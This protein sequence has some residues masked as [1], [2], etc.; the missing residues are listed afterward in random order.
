MSLIQG[1]RYTWD[2]NNYEDKTK[3]GLFTGEYDKH[4]GN[5]ILI[6]KNGERW[7]VPSKDLILVKH[8]R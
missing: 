7:S 6:T 3:S 5:A 2:I 1:K 4:N 8:K